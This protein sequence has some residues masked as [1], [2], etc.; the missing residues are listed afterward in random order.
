MLSQ[1]YEH[2]YQAD[3]IKAQAS[4][5]VS[6]WAHIEEVKARM[7]FS[8][9]IDGAYATFTSE[10]EL[11]MRECLILAEQLGMSMRIEGSTRETLNEGKTPDTYVYS[12]SMVSTQITA[13]YPKSSPSGDCQISTEFRA[14][15]GDDPLWDP[16]HV[17]SRVEMSETEGD[18]EIGT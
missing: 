14:K 16:V 4:R 1:I 17:P 6:A 5:V 11:C 3:A 10:I 13:Y 18:V 15:T 12:S 8:P 2:E 9:F 7:P